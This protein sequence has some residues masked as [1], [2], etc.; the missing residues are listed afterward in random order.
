MQ[1]IVA[2]APPITTTQ[3]A[4]VVSPDTGALFAALFTQLAT[5]ADETASTDSAAMPDDKD[6]PE[7]DAEI[8]PQTAD[9]V[10]D[11]QNLPV[12]S[13]LTQ[14]ILPQT[15]KRRGDIMVGNPQPI[16]QP[17]GSGAVTPAAINDASLVVA[18]QGTPPS[19]GQTTVQSK[20]SQSTIAAPVE[21]VVVEKMPTSAPATRDAALPIYA[22]QPEQTMAIALQKTAISQASK[23]KADGDTRENSAPPP[24]PAPTSAQS[25]P[26]NAA[27][28]A[29]AAAIPVD[30]DSNMKLATLST[31][32]GAIDMLPPISIGERSVQVAHTSATPTAGAETV[33]H[34]A[35]QMAV[36]ISA[37]QG[38]TTEIALNPEELGRVR[39][40]MS[41]VDT[42]ITL[43]VIAERPETTDL[44]R[45][46]IDALAQEFKAMGYDKI[47]FS[48]AG[49]GQA[50]AGDGPSDHAKN[51]Q[52]PGVVIDDPVTIL[53]QPQ[54]KAGLDL[55]L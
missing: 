46:H 5:I 25:T 40:T 18:L 11:D 32:D 1:L 27:M 51:P 16:L 53:Q 44:M 23:S 47:S 41:A 22:A 50:Q 8:G 39:L 15:H 6:A 29:P 14:P 7:T 45:R 55:R 13:V 31:L 36:A 49:E 37:R 26:I 17:T 34:A 30:R 43:T 28:I 2:P 35:H 21:A 38:Q 48:F 20:L 19:M 10:D 4:V 9:S 52:L 42:T 54:R 33:R 3:R 24:T 12:T